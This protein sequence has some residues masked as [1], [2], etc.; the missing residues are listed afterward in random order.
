MPFQEIDLQRISIIPISGGLAIDSHIINGIIF[1]KPFT[2]AGNEQQP[3]L[4][5]NPKILFLNNEVFIDLIVL[6]N[7]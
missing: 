1:K 6:F 4:I 2:Y 3:K 5:R 7:H